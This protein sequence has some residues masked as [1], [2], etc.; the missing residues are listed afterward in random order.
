MSPAQHLHTVEVDRL[1][2]SQGL[3][4][5]QRVVAAQAPLSRQVHGGNG[6]WGQG[7]GQCRRQGGCKAAVSHV[8]RP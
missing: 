2:A 5:C 8:V 7:D 4:P 6:G 3:Q 1:Q